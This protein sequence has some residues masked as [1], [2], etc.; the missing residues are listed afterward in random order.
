MCVWTCLIKERCSFFICSSS[1]PLL[2]SLAQQCG[3]NPIT[4]SRNVIKAFRLGKSN[5]LTRFLSFPPFSLSTFSLHPF[6]AF[7]FLLHSSFATASSFTPVAS[8]PSLTFIRTS[9]HSR[10]S[11]SPHVLRATAENSHAEH[12]RKADRNAAA[13]LNTFIKIQ[14]VMWEKMLKIFNHAATSSVSKQNAEITPN[15]GNQR[16]GLTLNIYVEDLR[17]R[18]TLGIN[19]DT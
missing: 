19:A 3:A 2:S 8:R 18:L 11:S 12:Q 6:S 14:N 15:A 16:R 5:P 1:L 9:Q 4:P 17:R 13:V 7:Y 10:I